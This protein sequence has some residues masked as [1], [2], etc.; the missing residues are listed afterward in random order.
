MNEKI[1]S[2]FSKHISVFYVHLFHSILVSVPTCFI[3]WSANLRYKRFPLH[4]LLCLTYETLF[5]QLS[6][7]WRDS[8][9]GK[10]SQ[11]IFMKGCKI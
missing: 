4:F 10:V 1:C 6:H 11:K 8:S 2:S 9:F 7:L 5:S 3:F